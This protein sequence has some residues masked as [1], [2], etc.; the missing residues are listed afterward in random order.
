MISDAKSEKEDKSDA[1]EED[2]DDDDLYPA[3][4]EG[5]LTNDIFLVILKKLSKRRFHFN[6]L[7]QLNLLQIE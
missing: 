1:K 2:D 5:L 7:P 6:V 4:K 3:D